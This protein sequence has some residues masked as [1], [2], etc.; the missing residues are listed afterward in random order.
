[1]ATPHST[2]VLVLG[3]GGLIG[4]YL[5]TDLLRRGFPVG[6]AARKFTR[7]QRNGLGSCAR[8]CAIGNFDAAQ[9]M[10]LLNETAADVV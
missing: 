9:L 5:A 10:A 7:A 3:A 8:E 6:A 2:K 4:N 1:M